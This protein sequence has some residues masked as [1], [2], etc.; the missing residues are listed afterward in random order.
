MYNIDIIILSIIILIITLLI[1]DIYLKNTTITNKFFNFFESFNNYDVHRLGPIKFIND[2][3]DIIGYYPNGTGDN[4]QLSQEQLD[5][6]SKEN[7]T[8]TTI[9]IPTGAMGEKG[10]TGQPG[11]KGNRGEIGPPGISYLGEPGEN[12]SP[13]PPCNDGSPAP[14]CAPCESGKDGTN[15]SDCS[16]GPTGPAGRDAENCSPGPTGPAGDNGSCE[17]CEHGEDGTNAS[18]CICQCDVCN[19]VQCTGDV[20]LNT[21]NGDFLRITAETSFSQDIKITQSNKICIGDSCI[22]KDI[23]EKINKLL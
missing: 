17:P 22:D 5:I 9:K 6:I 19:P 2:A 4:G 8:F 11:E 20:N 1:F 14:I 21:I 12:G 3:S 10:K 13:A 16:P 23:L 7:L 15:A 18:D